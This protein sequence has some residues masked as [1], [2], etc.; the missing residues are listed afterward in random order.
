MMDLE[1][2]SRRLPSA[3]PRVTSDGRL[4]FDW[5]RQ[6]RIARTCQLSLSPIFG[7]VVAFRDA[8]S[9]FVEL[10]VGRW[11][12]AKPLFRALAMTDNNAGERQR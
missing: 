7:M 4:R 12:F 3:G 9:Q 2:E 11:Q 1:A 10:P 5:Y 6:H 8:E